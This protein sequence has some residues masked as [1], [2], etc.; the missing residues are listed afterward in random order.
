MLK[1]AGQH[2]SRLRSG[3]Q[4]DE[5]NLQSLRRQN[6]DYGHTKVRQAQTPYPR[7][8]DPVDPSLLRQRLL[9]LFGGLQFLKDEESDK[10][11]SDGQSPES[12]AESFLKKRKEFTVCEYTCTRQRNM[13]FYKQEPGCSVGSNWRTV[14]AAKN[15]IAVSRTNRPRYS[16]CSG[17]STN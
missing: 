16:Q 10:S 14:A 5:D 7:I 9:E 8:E 6:K 3:I 12:R 15:S 4:F 1:K 17:L 13:A 2:R 11:S